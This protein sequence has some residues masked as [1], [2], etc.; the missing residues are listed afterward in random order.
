LAFL[1]SQRQ[2]EFFQ[3]NHLCF[4]PQLRINL[5]KLSHLDALFILGHD[6]SHAA[7]KSAARFWGLL[8]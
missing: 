6:P 1:K 5:L 4:I 8:P 7:E 2:L 3:T